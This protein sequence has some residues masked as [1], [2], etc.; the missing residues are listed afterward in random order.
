MKC[1]HTVCRIY[2]PDSIIPD[3]MT[4]I[5]SPLNRR[6]I[7]ALLWVGELSYVIDP[8]DPFY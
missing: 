1:L 6:A 2:I 7:V 5:M 8:C 3:I 4:C